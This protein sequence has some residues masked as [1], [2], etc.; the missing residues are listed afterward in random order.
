MVLLRYQWC[1]EN[2]KN[3]IYIEDNHEHLYYVVPL[4]GAQDIGWGRTPDPRTGPG[5]DV[6]KG[7]DELEPFGRSGGGGAVAVPRLR[8]MS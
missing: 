2:S 8:I 5:N 3:G 1:P 7:G 4:G 6:T